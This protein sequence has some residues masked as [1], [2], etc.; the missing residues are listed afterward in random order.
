M[1]TVKGV[2]RTIADATTVTHT[3]QPGLFGGVVRCMVDTYEAAAIVAGT[4]IEMGGEL[5]KGAQV[6]MV[7]LMTDAMGSSVTM[8]VGDA[9]SAARYMSAEDVSSAAAHWSDLADGVEYEIDMTTAATPDNQILITT[10]G[11]T[12]TGTVKLITFYTTD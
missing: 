6:L 8:S 4:V 5:P 1:A 7:C 10:A 12:A 11:A 2:N 3:L 9:E